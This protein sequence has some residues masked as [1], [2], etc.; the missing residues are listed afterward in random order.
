MKFCPDCHIHLNNHEV[1]SLFCMNCEWHG[2]DESEL[3]D[4]PQ[5]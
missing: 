4:E 3:L 5:N 2:E 1:A